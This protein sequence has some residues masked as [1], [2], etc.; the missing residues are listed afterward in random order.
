[1]QRCEGRPIDCAT[2]VSNRS[3]NTLP[4]SR[5][6]QSSQ[7]LHRK[8]PQSSGSTDQS[9]TTES[10]APGFAC[11]VPTTGSLRRVPALRRHVAEDLGLDAGDELDPLRT[12]FAGQEAVDVE[13][14]LRVLAVDHAQRVE[15]HTV[16]LQQPRRGHHLGVRGRAAL[17]NAV[18]VVQPL[19][20]VAAEADEELVLL[21]EG[22]PVLVEQR[23]VGLQVV[24]R[25]AG[26]AC[27][28]GPAVRRSCGSNP[29]PGSSARRPAS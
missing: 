26:P 15:G 27:G 3:T 7:T 9:V 19:R 24:L 11:G 4:I 5:A 20:P 28:G 14:E 6:C 17:G 21:Q 13:R 25:C 18:Q 2:A 1:M 10:G 8:A 12:Q 16:L 29:A 22:R 23:A